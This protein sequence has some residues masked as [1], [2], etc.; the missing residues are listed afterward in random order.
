MDPK[1]LNALQS[2]ME[3]RVPSQDVSLPIDF[4]VVGDRSTLVFRS[5]WW[6]KEDEVGVGVIAIDALP[7]AVGDGT[8]TFDHL[9]G[10]LLAPP[11]D[12]DQE[13]AIQDAQSRAHFA[14][15]AYLSKLL[16]WSTSELEHDFKP[17]IQITMERPVVFL[18][19]L[20]EAETRERQ[21]GKILL[22]DGRGSVVD[23]LV[24][25]EN[26]LA[27]TADEDGHLVRFAEQWVSYAAGSRPSMS[28]FL[29]WL[30]SQQ[31]YGD[32]SFDGS[33]VVSAAGDVQEIAL[34]AASE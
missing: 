3:L 2:G 15:P 19:Q 29:S 11:G 16:T 18:D 13:R 33:G 8:W 14:R 24:I 23:S 26:G 7:R 21:V 22:R 34:Q 9:E 17:W 6:Q 25:D 4:V 5:D 10:Y 12:A 1:L 27:A 28:E 20:V 32:F 30:A 31:V